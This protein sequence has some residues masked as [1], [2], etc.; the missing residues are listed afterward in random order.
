MIINLFS[1]NSEVFARAYFRENKTLTIV[2]IILSFIDVG[3]PYPT[4]TGQN[5]SPL[6]DVAVLNSAFP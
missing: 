1:V 6:N 5:Y 2:K 4:D 3:K